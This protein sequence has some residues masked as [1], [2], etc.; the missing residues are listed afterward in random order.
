MERKYTVSEI[1]DLRRVCDDR[2]L[3]GTSKRHPGMH[4]SRVYDPVERSNAVEN[5][6]RT[7]ML[8]G[9]TAEDIRAEDEHA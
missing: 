7:Y 3:W 8:A 6:V 5:M 4:S 1:D 9:I 2:F